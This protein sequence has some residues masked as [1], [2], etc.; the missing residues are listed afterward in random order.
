MAYNHWWWQIIA[1]KVT[2]KRRSEGGFPYTDAD[3]YTFHDIMCNTENGFYSYGRSNP[4]VNKWDYRGKSIRYDRNEIIQEA[5]SEMD[6]HEKSSFM[7]I[8][9]GSKNV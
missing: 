1:D 4:P 9:L 7:S 6:E 5:W 3:G 2:R 8:I